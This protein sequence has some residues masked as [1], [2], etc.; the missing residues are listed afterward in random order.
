MLIDFEGRVFWK[1]PFIHVLYKIFNDTNV[2]VKVVVN[3]LISK[4]EICEGDLFFSF[5]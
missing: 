3:V 5:H 2:Y 1:F 4:E